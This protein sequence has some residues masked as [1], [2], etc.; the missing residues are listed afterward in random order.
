MKSCN[1]NPSVVLLIMLTVSI[2]VIASPAQDTPR[3]QQGDFIAI[4]GDSITEERIYD[5]ITFKVQLAASSKNLETSPSNFKGLKDVSRIEDNG[6]YKYYYGGTSDYNRIQLMK[7][8]S[9]EKGYPSS[10]IVAFKDGKK[11]NLPEVL[12]SGDK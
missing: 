2:A 5:G 4:C 11:L 10:F 1:S 12:K 8:F 3:L 9:Q 7:T 6:L